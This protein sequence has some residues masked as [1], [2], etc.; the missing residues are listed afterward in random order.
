[1][2]LLYDL[3]IGNGVTVV[4]DSVFMRPTC[5][6]HRGAL[7]IG[8]GEDG[9]YYHGYDAKTTVQNGGKVI[10][11]GTTILRYNES[12]DAGLYIYGDGNDETV[13]FDCAY[14]VGAYPAPSMPK[15]LLSRTGY[16]L[17]K[18][19]MTTATMPTSI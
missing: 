15:T 7:V 16:F 19:P 18:T 14:Y 12:A 10:V 4:G 17:L 13:E 9:T 1:M 3:N 5:E 11:N 6:H 8:D 2:D